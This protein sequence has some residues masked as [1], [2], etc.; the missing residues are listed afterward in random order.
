G[1]S[2]GAVKDLCLD[3][4]EGRE[5]VVGG[6]DHQDL[7]GFSDYGLI[8]GYPEARISSL[9]EEQGVIDL[10]NCTGPRPQIG[11]KLFIIPNH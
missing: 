2:G 3:L 9:S 4:R 1:R 7:L 11:Q 6:F 10:S 5:E 8:V